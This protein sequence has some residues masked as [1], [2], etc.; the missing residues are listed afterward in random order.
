MSLALYEWRKLFRL[1]ALWVFVAL[2]LALNGIFI[3]EAATGEN[4]GYI[5]SASDA[6]SELGACVDADFV[7]GLAMLPDT[8]YRAALLEAAR[9]AENVF[10]GYDTDALSDFYAERVSSSPAAQRIMR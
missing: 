10:D 7:S 8:G 6:V 3:A 2:C 1:G 4:R 9:A 5:A